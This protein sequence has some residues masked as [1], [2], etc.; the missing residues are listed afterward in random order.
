MCMLHEHQNWGF[1]DVWACVL[2]WWEP[3]LHSINYQVNSPV[4]SNW[5]HA[6]QG[7]SGR[8]KISQLDLEVKDFYPTSSSYPLVVVRLSLMVFERIIVWISMQ[9]WIEQFAQ[10][11]KVG[12]IMIDFVGAFSFGGVVVGDSSEYFFIYIILQL[13]FNSI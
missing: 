2:I 11:G 13:W 8:C 12:L 9:G 7:G 10:R 1:I 6:H 4:C 3:S 5:G